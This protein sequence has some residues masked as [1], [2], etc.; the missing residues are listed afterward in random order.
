MPKVVVTDLVYSNAK[1]EKEILAPLNVELIVAHC[2][3]EEEV[4]RISKDAD[5]LMVCYAPITKKVMRS[6][7][8][9][10]GVIR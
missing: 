3:K 10:K 2:K 8:K 4:T 5:V 6:L 7:A 1:Y 9:C